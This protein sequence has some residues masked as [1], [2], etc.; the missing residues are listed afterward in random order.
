MGP[1]EPDPKDA[2]DALAK[3]DAFLESLGYLT[4]P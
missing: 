3:G 2:A 4:P 1:F